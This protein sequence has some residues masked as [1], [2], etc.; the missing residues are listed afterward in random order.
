MTDRVYIDCGPAAAALLE[1]ELR[2]RAEGL[3]IH[4]GDPAP[5]ALRD[6]IGDAEVVLNGHTPMD[7]GLLGALQRLRRIV[8]LGSGPASYI[9][10]EAARAR[11]V[12]VR[13]VVNYGDVTI[14]EHALALIFAVA[15]NVAVH[16]A[17]MRRGEWR[18]SPGFQLAGATLGVV[19]AGGV[20]REMMRLGAGIGM[21][22]L[23]AARRAPQTDLPA[24][25]VGMDDL[26][27]RADVVSLHLALASETEGLIGAQELARMKPRA[28]LVNTARGALVDE[29]ALADALQSGHLGGAGLDVFRDEPLPDDA[30]IRHA[31]HTVLTPHVAWNTPQAAANLLRRGLEAMN[32]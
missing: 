12:E 3:R 11:E 5:G 19:G 16:D 21:E 1:G 18:G 23:V 13:R 28:L 9:D 26:L 6:V 24:Q 25:H 29:A 32:A 7:G 2:D 14:A 30:P 4:R 20:G 8:F 17:D 27:T 31:P 22:V 15:R 10:M